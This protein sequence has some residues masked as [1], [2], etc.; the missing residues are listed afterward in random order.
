MLEGIW[1]SNNIGLQDQHNQC[2]TW[3]EAVV[4]REQ[5]FPSQ[6]PSFGHFS[7]ALCL[8]R[9]FKVKQTGHHVGMRGD[10]EP[11]NPHG[12]AAACILGLRETRI[13]TRTTLTRDQTRHSLAALCVYFKLWSGHR[14]MLMQFSHTSGVLCSVQFFQSSKPN[15]SHLTVAIIQKRLK[16][17]HKINDV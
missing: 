13:T 7:K 12:L 10:W 9:R 17:L 3:Q 6:F 1:F 14:R 2:P 8:W 4:G 16:M 11:P 5:W 15:L